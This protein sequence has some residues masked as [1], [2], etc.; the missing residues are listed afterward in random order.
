[1]TTA[2]KRDMVIE[3]FLAKREWLS[4]SRPQVTH[5]ERLK[6][7]KAVS[8]YDVIDIV[9]A[10]QRFSKSPM[11]DPRKHKFNL[12]YLMHGGVLETWIEF[13]REHRRKE[14]CTWDSP[15]SMEPEEVDW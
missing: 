4:G 9:E 8:N 7:E 6:V 3:T 5:N 14:Q 2:A 12:S 10:I 11:A 13:A 1:M 15:S